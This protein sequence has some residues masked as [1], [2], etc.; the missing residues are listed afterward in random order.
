MPHLFKLSS[1]PSYSVLVI[2]AIALFSPKFGQAQGFPPISQDEL[3]MTSEPQAP[4][5]PAVILFR[6]V[7]RDDNGLT[8]HE[9][10][11]L[12]V[13]ILTEE[14]RQQ[15]NVEIAFNKADQDVV[16][17]HARTIHPDGSVVDFD[18]K[19]ME[20]LI[21]KTQGFKYLA[22]T[23]S[24][25]DV[26]VGSIIEYRFTYDF[27][28]H[29]LFESHWVV[30]SN[31]F[32]KSA[33]FALKPYVP[34]FNNPWNVRWTWQGLPSGITPAQGP[35][36]VVRMEVQN[37]PAFQ[38]ED[39][40]PPPNELKAR[41]DFIYENEYFDRE[42]DGYWRHV[43]KKRYEALE[44]F[45]GKHKTMDEAVA[46]IVSPSDPPE[47]KLRKIYD[48]VQ[49]IR[50]TSYEIRKSAQEE[51]RDKE[52]PAENVEEV[53]KRGYG[54][55]VQLTWLYLGLVRAAGFEAYGVWA[56]SRRS[57]FFTPKTME[58]RKLSANVVLV[59]LNGKDLFFDPGAAFT[60]FGMLTWSETGTPGLCLDKNG[61][62]WVKTSLP[63]SSESRMER[64]AKLKLTE[65]GTL[66][67]AVTVT[68]TGLEAMYHR[69]DVRNADDVT[70]KKFLETRLRNQLPVAGEVELTNKPD[71]TDSESPL[72]AEFNVS[73]PGWASNAGKRTAVPAAV[74][75][76]IEKRLFEH[77]ERVHPIYIEYPYQKIDDVAIELPAGWQISSV[78]S[79]QLL[80]GHIVTYTLKVENDHATLHLTR[81]LTWDF[82]FLEPKYYSALRNFF[83]NVRTS[84]DQQIVLQPAASAAGS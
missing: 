78:P 7:D 30:S 23:F 28:E 25:P 44:S 70:R 67:G 76:A 83:Q 1:Q 66:E 74:F 60:P 51:K 80:D 40:M 73:I 19:V 11:Y 36:R 14:G 8:S 71:W 26:Q 10:H 37:I 84:D 69:L 21:E 39:F 55:G 5:A 61:G 43:G 41:V 17:I 56:S 13:K 34:R 46:Q 27:K 15:G 68:Y 31:L 79:P 65:S 2:I 35:D 82:L 58:N 52:K 9:D 57:Y 3:K 81:K 63:Q 4:G 16:N 20:K 12:R 32:T 48:R 72:V 50:N 42:P 77:A 53:W 64:S 47:V 29:M 38:M 24:L 33:R 45:V 59:K 18:G 75:T 6:E 54:T 22:K 62:T 49:Q